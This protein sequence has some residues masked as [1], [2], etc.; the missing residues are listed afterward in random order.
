M[1]DYE[2]IKTI[3]KDNKYGDPSYLY[4]ETPGQEA[5]FT[6]ELIERWGMVAAEQDGEDSSGRAK[7]R[8]MT[9]DELA[10]R[11]I[12]TT[13]T[14]FG[15]LRALGWITQMPDVPVEVESESKT[16]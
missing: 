12:A 15:R 8:L 16:A 5:R 1:S 2:P 11:A 9:P 6:L 14:V 3:R 10:E 4:A 7:L 13:A